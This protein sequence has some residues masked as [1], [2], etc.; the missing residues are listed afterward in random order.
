MD[1]PILV[2]LR[3]TQPES[4]AINAASDFRAQPRLRDTEHTKLPLKAELLYPTMAGRLNA[5]T[6]FQAPA[7]LCRKV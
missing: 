4:T 1:A 3:S 7:F 6:A 2:E 5:T